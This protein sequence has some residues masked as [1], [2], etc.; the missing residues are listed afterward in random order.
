MP[1]NEMKQEHQ[2][3]SW[4]SANTT[5]VMGKKKKTTSSITLPMSIVAYIMN[6][7]FVFFPVFFF[8]LVFPWWRW[9]SHGRD[10]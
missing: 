9:C 8:S 5:F 6:V 10:A 4:C 1:A 3:R 2:Q 7:F